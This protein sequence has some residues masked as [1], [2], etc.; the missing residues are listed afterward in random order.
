MRGVKFCFAIGHSSP[1]IF[2][3]GVFWNFRHCMSLPLMQETVP[4]ATFSPNKRHRHSAPAVAVCAA[5]ATG[6]KQKPGD[7]ETS[8]HDPIVTQGGAAAYVQIA[9]RAVFAALG[10]KLKLDGLGPS[11]AIIG[12]DVETQPAFLPQAPECQS[13]EPR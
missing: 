2:H 12:L 8:T 11:A 5:S 6:G 9:F 3:E 4:M 13:A 1:T 10:G 7:C